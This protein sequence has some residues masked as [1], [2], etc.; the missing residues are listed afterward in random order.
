MEK[1]LFVHTLINLKGKRQ[2]WVKSAYVNAA[3]T[4]KPEPQQ[5]QPEIVWL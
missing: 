5:K 1:N 2:I 4:E 3:H